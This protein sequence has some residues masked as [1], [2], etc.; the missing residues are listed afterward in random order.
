MTTIKQAWNMYAKYNLI[1]LSPESKEY[2]TAKLSFYSGIAGY[3]KCC[4]NIA[5]DKD[6]LDEQQEAHIM[7][8][9]NELQNFFARLQAPGF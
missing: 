6:V 7:A 8:L 1:H 5:A 3:L 4:T 9:Q 2:T